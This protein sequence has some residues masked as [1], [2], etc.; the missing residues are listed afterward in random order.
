[1]RGGG[2][3]KKWPKSSD[4]IYERPLGKHL[5]NHTNNFDSQFPFLVHRSKNLL[6]ESAL[7]ILNLFILVC[8]GRRNLLQSGW[9]RPK[10]ILL[11]VK[12]VCRCLFSIKFMQKS[13]WARAHSAHP[14]LTTL[15]IAP[16]FYNHV[17]SEI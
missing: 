15:F 3:V 7:T 10:T 12:R 4:V 9:E 16:I 2:G 13:G 1:M 6:I 5:Q 11:I 14:A 17:Q 8:Q